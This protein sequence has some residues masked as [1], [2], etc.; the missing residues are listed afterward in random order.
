ME[1]T[2]LVVEDDSMIRNLIRTYLKKNNYE[3]V[4]AEN[5]EEA[6]EVFLTHR[7]CLIILDLMMPVMSGEGFI[8]WLQKDQQEDT[9]VIMLTA[10]AATQDKVSGL[11]LGA[12]AYMTKPFDLRSEEHTSE[13]QSRFE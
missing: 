5:G 11:N 13:L 9:A 4:E 3:V 10:K 1:Q 6:K 7:P 2:I 12:D 8:Q